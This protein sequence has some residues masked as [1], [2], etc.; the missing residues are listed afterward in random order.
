MAAEAYL[1]H[2]VETKI[3]VEYLAVV[4]CLSCGRMDDGTAFY[5]GD[6]RR[7]QTDGCRRITKYNR[8]C[9]PNA[10]LKNAGF[11]VGKT[12]YL[13]AYDN[14]VFVTKTPEYR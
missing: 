8:L 2:G 4:T 1:V 14:I 9:V 5:F 13:I 10:L 12:A 7:R 11:V 6:K 3:G